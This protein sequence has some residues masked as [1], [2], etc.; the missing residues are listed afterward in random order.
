MTNDSRI[1]FLEELS[2]LEENINGF[3]VR[4]NELTK[5]NTQLKN[6]LLNLHKLIEEMKSTISQKDE[7]IRKLK[8]EIEK[9]KSSIV[10]SDKERQALKSKIAE[11]LERI[12]VYLT[13]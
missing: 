1:K 5:E 6:D 2:K 12:E 9:L 11:I 7:E 13:N 8:V 3:I 4:F 10:L